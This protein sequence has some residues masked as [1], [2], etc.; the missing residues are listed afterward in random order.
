MARKKKRK[1]RRRGKGYP[2]RVGETIDL[3]NLCHA[4][5]LDARRCGRPAKVQLG[6]V[7]LCEQHANTERT[8]Q[9]ALDSH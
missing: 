5:T 8:S 3:T 2:S 9:M 4:R 7:A 6:K 1:R